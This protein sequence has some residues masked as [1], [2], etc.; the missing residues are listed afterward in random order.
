MKLLVAGRNGQ[1][2]RSLAERAAAR[3]LDL[4]ALGRPDLDLTEPAGIAPALQRDR[5]DIVVNAAA[6]TAVD[7][8]ES[9]SEAAFAIN[10]DGAGALAAQCAE[11]DIPIIH[12]STDYVF[13]GGKQAAYVETDPVDPL[14]VYGQS[15]LAGERAVIAANPRHIVLRTAWVYSPFGHNFVRTMLR[16]AET[17]D[18]L[19]V[20][21]DQTGNPTYAP[22]L[23]AAIFD[24]AAALRRDR[25]RR[26]GIYHAAGTGDATWYDF[27]S[28]IFARSAEHGGRRPRL[29]AITTADYPTPA[30]RPANSR[31]DCRK[32]AQA[33][34]ITLPHWRDGV[35][36]CID[37]LARHHAIN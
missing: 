16:L 26:W 29:R 2:A 28:E 22:Q 30:P 23:A 33:F 7:T 14:G 3:G 8:A 36:D 34:G 27:A 17:R 32:L 12:I 37:R 15:K 19:G 31:L 21:A 18:E 10:A 5:P 6:Y 1:V 4:V 25:E 20:V 13:D 9:D 11:L 35:R 24:I